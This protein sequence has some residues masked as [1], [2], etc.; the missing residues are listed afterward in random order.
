MAKRVY[1]GQ[2]HG[3]TDSGACANGFK[4]KNIT[5]S[6]GKYCNERLQQYDGVLT[7]LSRTA[8]KDVSIDTKVAQSDSFGADVCMDIHINAGGGN[9]CEIYYSGYRADKA[10]SKALASNIEAAL[11]SVGQVS[12]GLK[13]KSNNTG[14][15]DYFG[16]V[17]RP[18]APSV[19]IECGFIDNKT[20]LARFD[21]AVEQ[22]KFGYAIADGTAKYLNLKLKGNK[23]MEYLK[24]IAQY[25]GIKVSSNMSEK[26]VYNAVHDFDTALQKRINKA[27]TAAKEI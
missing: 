12:R 23:G 16:M 1:I 15:A 26:D 27:K 24:K 2:G 5:L 21:T 4:E 18:D 7:Q 13:I 22:K 3:G 17:R 10:K 11:K 14:N 20:D 19:L 6:I 8:D 25:K 9:G